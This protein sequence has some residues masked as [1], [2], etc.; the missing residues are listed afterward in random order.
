M[1]SG[2]RAGVGKSKNCSKNT[3]MFLCHQWQGPLLTSYLTFRVY[4]ARVV[5]PEYT[6]KFLLSSKELTHQRPRSTKEEQ[7]HKV[8]QERNSS[9]EGTVIDEAISSLDAFRSQRKKMDK[10]MSLQDEGSRICE[11]FGM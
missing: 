4:T 1:G 8:F 9:R 11:K 7:K 6:T 10:R 3:R 2:A 5:L